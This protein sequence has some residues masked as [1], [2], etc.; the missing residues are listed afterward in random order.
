M[1]RA[2][3]AF[4]NANENLRVWNLRQGLAPVL[5]LQKI[6]GLFIAQRQQT[7]HGDIVPRRSGDITGARIIRARRFPS[8]FRQQRLEIVGRNAQTCARFVD[9]FTTHQRIAHARD[10]ICQLAGQ[11]DCPSKAR[12]L[13][14]V[15]IA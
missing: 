3:I 13:I 6:P 14:C 5:I 8:L 12:P 4:Q 11:L 10:G 9:D 1:V 7:K 15:L 2:K